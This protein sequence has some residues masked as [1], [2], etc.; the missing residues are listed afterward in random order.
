MQTITVTHCKVQYG[1]EY[2]RFLYENTQYLP[3]LAQIKRLF[4]FSDPEDVILKYK[5]EDGD[6]VTI[7]SDEELVFAIGLFT[8][9]VLRLTVINNHRQTQKCR[10]TG[11]HAP[12]QKNGDF[13]RDR[14][15]Q[16][17]LA[18][19]ELLS[20][21][22]NKLTEKKDQIRNR[23]DWIQQKGPHPRFPNRANHLEMKL[24]RIESFLSDL[25]N[26]SSQ[27]PSSDPSHCP[28]F[29]ESPTNPSMTPL[30]P[31]DLA[32]KF[33]QSKDLREQHLKALSDIHIELQ[34]LK[35][36]IQ[37]ARLQGKAGT[38][39]NEVHQRILKLKE[40]I[41]QARERHQQKKAELQ[42]FDQSVRAMRQLQAQRKEQKQQQKV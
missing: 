9:S 4:G 16:K 26:L 17:L 36:Q 1:N 27:N 3:L 12:H 29:T 34:L 30:H 13:W 37:Q 15:H 39:R 28:S 20:K 8:G 10:G 2:R 22:I 23:L 19:P 33:A 11:E 5:D 25:Q 18:N 24:K 42:A 40:E 31:E 14:W 7:S 38:P 6:M 21:K 41:G 32:E 35:I